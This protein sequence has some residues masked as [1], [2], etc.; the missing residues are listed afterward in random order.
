MKVLGLIFGSQPPIAGQGAS[1]TA[2]FEALVLLI[3]PLFCFMLFYFNFPVSR[4]DHAH[5]IDTTAA[6]LSLCWFPYTG[7][8]QFTV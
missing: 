4:Y 7:L 6:L 5:H 2:C 3:S 8:S 1:S